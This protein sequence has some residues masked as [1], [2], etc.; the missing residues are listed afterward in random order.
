M[1]VND[2]R[3]EYL[4]IACDTCCKPAPPNREILAAHGLMHGF[5]WYCSGGVHICATCPHP[6][7]SAVIT[8]YTTRKGN[9]EPLSDRGTK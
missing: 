9:P 1:I 8:G 6:T 2:A 7:A 3:G 4:H 5:Q